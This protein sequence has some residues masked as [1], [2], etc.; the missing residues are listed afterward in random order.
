MN[1]D[2]RYQR[3]VEEWRGW[4]PLEAL[5]PL[6]PSPPFLKVSFGR[7]E[8]P[9]NIV[10]DHWILGHLRTLKAICLLRLEELHEYAGKS[11][12]ISD[13]QKSLGAK[14]HRL[15]SPPFAGATLALRITAKT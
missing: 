4:N 14:I 9:L 13:A 8:D 1:S 6:G 10:E 3:K 5:A 2:H 12:E 11:H 7:I 15:G